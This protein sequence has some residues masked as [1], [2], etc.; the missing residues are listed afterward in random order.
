MR[1]SG[2]QA[3]TTRSEAHAAGAR[4][5]LAMDPTQVR[6]T[7]MHKLLERQLRRQFGSLDAVPP[8][9]LPFLESVSASYREADADRLLV[10]RSLELTSQELMQRNTELRQR[11]L[12]RLQFLNN[13]AHELGTPLTPIRLQI[14]LLRARLAEGSPDQRK[15]VDILERNFERLGQLVRDL[16][17]S[18][19]LQAST[20][21]LHVQPIDLG[22]VIY[23][24][25]ENYLEPAR[26]AGV[27]LQV[28]EINDLTVLADGSRLGQ[29]FDNLLSNALKFTERGRTIR[30]EAGRQG[31]MAWATVRD[32]GAGMRTSE[33][34]RL[35]QPFSQIHDTMQRTRGGTGLGLYVSRGIVEA[36]GGSITAASEGLGKGSTFT[37]RVPLAVEGPPSGA[38]SSRT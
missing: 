4:Q 35:F 5:G 7:P 34:H 31:A 3:S 12:E 38:I 27:V 25:A 10:E 11:D 28:D 18:A 19:R 21:K 1:D 8:D 29:V 9:L 20:L 26:Q 24:A 23:H 6:G 14:H 22:L 37:V 2:E 15:A 13:A 36:L 17:D 32:E 16:L 30:V 33:L